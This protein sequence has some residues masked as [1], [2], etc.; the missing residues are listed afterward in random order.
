LVAHLLAW[1]RFA[2]DSLI[3][4]LARTECRPEATRKHLRERCDGLAD[5]RGVVALPGCVDHAERHVGGGQRGAE[6]GPREAGL[7]LPR[8]PRAEVVGRHAGGEAGLFGLLDIVEQLTRVDLLVRTVKTDDRHA[9]GIPV[10]LRGAYVN[11]RSGV[12]AKATVWLDWNGLAVKPH[13]DNPYAG[14]SA[15]RQ[16]RRHCGGDSGDRP[17]CFSRT[18]FEVGV[19]GERGMSDCATDAIE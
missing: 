11:V 19:R 17:Q 16:H 3:G 1:P 5:D 2:G 15:P 7:T 9:E 10:L 13:R 12:A 18:A 14:R 6:E 4:G 8:A